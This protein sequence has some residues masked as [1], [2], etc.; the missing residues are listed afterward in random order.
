MGL[1]HRPRG[2]TRQIVGGT[3]SDIPAGAAGRGRHI[4]LA[5]YARRSRMTPM[6]P[7]SISRTSNVQ[8]CR[9]G[10]A[11]APGPCASVTVPR[12]AKKF[13]GSSRPSA[14]IGVHG[15]IP[16]PRKPLPDLLG[17]YGD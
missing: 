6:T 15:M 13:D 12:R 5:G 16:A 7:T 14:V 3:T 1:V 2:L 17:A 9:S 10:T 8:G 11:V 4:R